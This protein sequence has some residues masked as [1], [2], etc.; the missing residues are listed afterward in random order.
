MGGYVAF[1]FLRQFPQRVRGVCLF[2][3]RANADTPETREK[4]FKTIEFLEKNGIEEFFPKVIPNLL[5]KTTLAS[6]PAVEQEVKS[7]IRENSVNGICDTLRAMAA[8]RDS[9]ELLGAI[10]CPTLVVAGEE[11]GFV[12][13]EESKAMHSKIPGADFH[14][15]EHTGH[16]LNLEK[17]QAFEEIVSGFLA[18]HF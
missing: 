16:L 7:L 6:N 1:E 17:P 13:V 11:D 9:T 10:S 5:G 4:R 14:L 2:A 3:T 15:M 12:T 18:R 8:R